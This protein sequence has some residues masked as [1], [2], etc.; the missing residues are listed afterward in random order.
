MA[1]AT[2]RC[3][4]NADQAERNCY[5]NQRSMLSSNPYSLPQPNLEITSYSLFLEDPACLSD[6]AGFVLQNCL[7]VQEPSNVVAGINTYWAEFSVTNVDKNLDMMHY[8]RTRLI[9]GVVA[10]DYNIPLAYVE[11]SH[12]QDITIWLEF[13][14]STQCGEH[15]QDWWLI[16]AD[17][18]LG[19]VYTTQMTI[20]SNCQ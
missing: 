20:T 6:E 4:E 10:I 13:P 1:Y 9:D 11:Q 15:Q 14:N 3:R 12:P 16:D 8:R 18:N 19:P 5:V 2:T 7:I 17:G